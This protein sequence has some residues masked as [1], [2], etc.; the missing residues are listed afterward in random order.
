MMF[1]FAS[2]PEDQEKMAQQAPKWVVP[3]TPGHAPHSASA[4]GS[5]QLL[6]KVKEFTPSPTVALFRAIYGTYW[7]DAGHSIDTMFMAC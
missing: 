5:W 6:Q 7:K 4:G 2:V 1:A 3:V